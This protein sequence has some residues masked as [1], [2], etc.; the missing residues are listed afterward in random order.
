MVD[1]NPNKQGMYIPGTSQSIVPPEFLKEF[2]PDVIIIM[3]PVYKNEIQETINKL[4]L[5]NKNI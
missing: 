2:K 4:E 1:I 5:T 3:N